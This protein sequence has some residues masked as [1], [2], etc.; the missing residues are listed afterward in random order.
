MK[1]TT[2]RNTK[3]IEIIE[4][5]VDIM[6]VNDP[7]F[8]LNRKLSNFQSQYITIYLFQVPSVQKLIHKKSMG[9]DKSRIA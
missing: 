9:K 5:P 6:T 7:L 1:F 2:K 3:H 8:W 4:G